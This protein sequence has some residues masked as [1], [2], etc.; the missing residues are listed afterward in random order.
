MNTKHSPIGRRYAAPAG[1]TL[2]EV[3]VVI[4]II[5][6]L[7]AFILPAVQQARESARRIQCA[8]NL[9]NIGVATHNFHASHGK[10]PALV[11]ATYGPTFWFS[12]L[13]YLDQGALY[14]LY[15]GGATGAA[16]PT[17]LRRSMN[18]N[19]GIIREA[20]QEQSVVGIPVYHCP[21]YRPPDV[22]RTGDD[23]GGARG[24]KSDYAVIAMRTAA[25]NLTLKPG[26]TVEFEWWNIHITD[27]LTTDG[28]PWWNETRGA[29]RPAIGTEVTEDD[30]GIDGVLGRRRA[31]APLSTS[32]ADIT[33]GA[34]NTFLVGEKYLRSDEL[35]MTGDLSPTNT[36]GSCFVNGFNWREYTAARNIR[37][38]LIT[39][40][41]AT[42][43]GTITNPDYSTGFGSW[44]TGVVHF[45]MADGTVRHINQNIDIYLQWRLGDRSDGLVV[46][47]F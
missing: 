13:P 38:P 24:P 2:V 9:K 1:F 7:V 21:T 47:D 34:S 32:F 20:G 15:D 22:R 36:D 28:K 19:Y 41:E 40:I 5:G 30:G 6:L 27:G 35:M 8:N 4:A 33:D 42:T 10:F 12:I 18:L 25:N 29:I 3:M 17:S 11:T 39:R 44:H 23:T 46:G 16:G 14:N 45:L 37:Y 26:N 43:S 31:Q